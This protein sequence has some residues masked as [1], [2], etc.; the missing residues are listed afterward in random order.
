[1]WVILFLVLLAI[2][3]IFSLFAWLF[4]VWWIVMI[5]ILIAALFTILVFVLNEKKTSDVSKQS[6][7]MNKI[8]IKKANLKKIKIL[9][10]DIDGTSTDFRTTEA[11]ESAHKAGYLQGLNT[12]TIRNSASSIEAYG[13][14]F[15]RMGP[16]FMHVYNNMKKFPILF[17]SNY[18]HPSKNIACRG[19]PQQKL[20]AMLR[21]KSEFPHATIILLDDLDENVDFVRSAGFQAIKIRDYVK[22]AD[23][24]HLIIQ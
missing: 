4:K 8:E 16:G 10:Y 13:E 7:V 23:I 15:G 12:N 3:G 18:Q 1:M 14:Y 20:C 11:M 2:V 21:V 5:G 9:L 24:N 17:N 6:D 19:G 22:L